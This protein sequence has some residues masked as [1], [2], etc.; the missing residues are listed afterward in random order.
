M[1]TVFWSENL[2]GRDHTENVGVNRMI[3]L[4]WILGK[5]CGN[6]DWIRLA[7]DRNIWQALMNTV[8]NHLVP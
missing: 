5:R 6:V 1:R 8:M 2:K 7:Q 4:E 3:I